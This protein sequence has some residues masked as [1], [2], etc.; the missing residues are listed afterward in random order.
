MRLKDSFLT[1]AFLHGIVITAVLAYSV[2]VEK[3]DDIVLEL[4]LTE[5]AK[6]TQMVEQKSQQPAISKQIIASQSVSQKHS[7]VTPEPLVT[8]GQP[9]QAQVEVVKSVLKPSLEPVSEPILE[10]NPVAMTQPMPAPLPRPEPVNIEQEYLDSHLATIRDLLIKY[11]KYPT[12]AVRLKQEGDVRISFRLKN[13][14]EVEDIKILGSSGYE[15]LDEDAM[16]L[17]QKT[18]L[19]FPKPSKSVRI[20]VPLRYNLR[21]TA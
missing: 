19:Y 13:N 18:A 21:T 11:R 6:P 7:M 4:A 10:S 16:K 1:S 20:T 5:P 12:Q 15:L 2:P 3:E 14:G 9:V 8:N 17:I